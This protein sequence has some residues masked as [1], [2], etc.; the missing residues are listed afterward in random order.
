MRKAL[1]AV[2]VLTLAGCATTTPDDQQGTY[3]ERVYRTGSNLPVRD[4][5][6]ADVKTVGAGAADDQIRGGMSSPR[7]GPAAGG[8]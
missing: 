2:T 7:V 6:A 1:L 3:T 4:R 8:R 5:D